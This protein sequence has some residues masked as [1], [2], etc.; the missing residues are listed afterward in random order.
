[1]SEY[2]NQDPYL[3]DNELDIRVSKP[4]TSRFFFL[5]GLFG[6]FLFCWAGCYNLY[7]HKFKSPADGTIKVNESSLLDPKY[8]TE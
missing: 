2:N 8:K 6:F 3:L 1:M 5:L 7:Q 4:K